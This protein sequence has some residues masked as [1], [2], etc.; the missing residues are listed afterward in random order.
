[1][2]KLRFAG[3]LSL[4][5][6]ILT[7]TISVVHGARP[8]TILYR[9]LISIAIFGIAGFIFGGIVERFFGRTLSSQSPK[10]DQGELV[11]ED[12]KIENKVAAESADFTPFTP[13]N[14]AHVIRD[15]LD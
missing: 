8:M 7:L 11:G 14:L 13:E 9:T 1:M 15:Q 6:A 3:C 4:V 2:Y 10:E 12:K 5:V